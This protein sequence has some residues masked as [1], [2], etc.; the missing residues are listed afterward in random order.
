M[1][2]KFEGDAL[3]CCC[4]WEEMVVMG[5][6]NKER[7]E[8][9]WINEKYKHYRQ[10]LLKGERKKLEMCRKCNKGGC[11]SEEERNSTR[12]TQGLFQG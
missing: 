4:D 1:Y 10:T 5:N 8:H 2:I 11:N 3:L 9:I 12:T 6:A 7:L